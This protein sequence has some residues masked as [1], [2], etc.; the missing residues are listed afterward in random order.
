MTE[1]I[2]AFL[3][4]N[5]IAV[6]TVEMPDGAPHSATVHFA[7]KDEPLAFIFLTGQA[8]RKAEPLLNGKNARASLVIGTDETQMKTFQLDG[9]AMLTDA[10]EYKEAYFSKFPEKKET[11]NEAT[12]VFI[13]FIP[14]WWRYTDMKSPEGKKIITS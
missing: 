1:D 3:G 5:R 6:L 9:T 4:E 11:Y 8:T 10:D 7:H 14:T 13:V 2:H 12:S